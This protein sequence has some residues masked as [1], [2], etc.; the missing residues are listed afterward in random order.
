MTAPRQGQREYTVCVI[1]KSGSMQGPYDASLQKLDAAKRANIAMVLEKATID[2]DDQIGIVAF[3]SRAEVLLPLSPLR[4]H[5]QQ[6]IQTIQAIQIR[7]G[8]DINSGL[9]AARGMLDR[10]PSSVVGRIIL[11]T[12]GHGGHPI[13]TARKLKD[14]GVVIDVIGVGDHPTNVDEKLLKKV[15]SVVQG[16]LKYRFIKDMHTLVTTYQ[17]LAA[18]TALGS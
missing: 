5:R 8:T 9:K 14:N 18:K 2:P 12:D 11:L 10:L 6:I 17:G 7:G 13:R 16:E 4:S 15:A 3:D 1:D